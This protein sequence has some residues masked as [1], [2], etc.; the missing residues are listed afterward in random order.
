MKEQSEIMNNFLIY[1]KQHMDY[2]IA[3]RCL[4]YIAL[5]YIFIQTIYSSLTTSL[6]CRED[7]NSITSQQYSILKKQP[8]FIYHGFQV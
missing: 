8:M 7:W 3:Y 5:C 1:Q 4:K 6:T 2:I